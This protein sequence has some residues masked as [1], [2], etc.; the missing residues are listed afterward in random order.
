MKNCIIV[1]HKYGSVAFQFNDA[2]HFWWQR[3]WVFVI[4]IVLTTFQIKQ[5]DIPTAV[6]YFTLAIFPALYCAAALLFT[7]ATPCCS[8][9]RRLLCCAASSHSFIRQSSSSCSFSVSCKISS[10]RAN[11]EK[12]YLRGM[13]GQEAHEW[14]HKKWNKK[15]IVK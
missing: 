5:T 15:K 13:G 2:N 8:S 4:I 6:F 10:C 11:T 14:K 3:K 1:L 9:Q 12:L 7:L